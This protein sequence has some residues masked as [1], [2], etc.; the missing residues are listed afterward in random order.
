MYVHYIIDYIAELLGK[1]YDEV[2]KITTNNA[3]RLWHL[4]QVK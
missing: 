4:D 1:S 3:R 2:A